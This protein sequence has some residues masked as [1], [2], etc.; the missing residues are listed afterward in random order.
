VTFRTG[1]SLRG[2]LLTSTVIPA[3]AMAIGLGGVSQPGYADHHGG[4]NPCAAK[5]CS[6][7][8]PCNPCAAKACN[9]CNPC[10]AKSCNPCNPCAGS[11]Y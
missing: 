2:K 3:M 1:K 5:A 4:C 8:N 10:A 6:A 9:P 7:C 11:N